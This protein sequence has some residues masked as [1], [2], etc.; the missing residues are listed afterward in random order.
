MTGSL[1]D[2]PRLERSVNLFNGLTQWVQCMVL[3]RSTPQQR[4]EVIVKLIDVTKVNPPLFLFFLPFHRAYFWRTRCHWRFFFTKT[5]I[6]SFSSF[7][8]LWRCKTQKL[9]ELRNF[10][11]LMAVVGGLSH[12]SLARLTRTASRIPPDSQ[13]ALAEL[14]EFLSSSSNFS[15]YRRAL[16]ECKGFK[17]PIL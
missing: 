3:S 8:F 16:Q 13:R 6:K 2:N 5:K 7:F 14:T 4:A 15:N 17:I 12:S 1:N 9:K 11:S 10:N